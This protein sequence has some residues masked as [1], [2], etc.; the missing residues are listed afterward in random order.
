MKTNIVPVTI[1]PQTATTLEIIGAN[2]RTFSSNGSANIVWALSDS[3]GNILKSG[4]EELSGSAYQGWN[5]DEPYLMNWL[6]DRLG[7]TAV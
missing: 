6:L 2:I 4:A 1:F 5:D 3:N 7:L